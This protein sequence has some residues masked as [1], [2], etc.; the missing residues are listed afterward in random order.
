[1]TIL[2]ELLATKDIASFIV[3]ENSTKSVVSA[4]GKIPAVSIEDFLD[5]A[6]SCDFK[7]PCADEKKEVIAG[8]IKQH[9]FFEYDPEILATEI[10]SSIRSAQR[11]DIIDAAYERLRD[12][13]SDKEVVL[14]NIIHEWG[15]WLASNNMVDEHVY[16][17]AKIDLILKSKELLAKKALIY[18]VPLPYYKLRHFVDLEYPEWHCIK[19]FGMG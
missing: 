14:W 15:L 8:F 12:V 13:V 10:A 2:H 6:I 11:S 19:L 5:Q 7:K 16:Y 4:Y 18:N 17:N 3:L 1:M 9:M